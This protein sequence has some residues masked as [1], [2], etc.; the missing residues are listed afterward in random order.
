MDEMK[1]K[2]YLNSKDKEFFSLASKAIFTNPFSE[3]WEEIKK[4]EFKFEV[5]QLV[6]CSF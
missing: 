4:G 1:A 5:Q 6:K 3:E 2:R